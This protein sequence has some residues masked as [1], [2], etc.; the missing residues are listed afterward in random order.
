M[1]LL[2]APIVAL[3]LT[4]CQPDET[5]AAYGAAGVTWQLIELDNAPFAATATLEFPEPGRITG[6]APCNSYFAELTV[7]YPWFE[8]S[9]IG[10]TRRA[11]PD[12]EAETTY[13]TALSEMELSEVSGP[14]LLLT[15]A[16]GRSMLFTPQE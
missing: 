1:K 5:V 3:F 2:L 12:L 4:S 9:P 16:A 6:S 11:C 14:T 10:A 13:F 7:P 15:N 8:L